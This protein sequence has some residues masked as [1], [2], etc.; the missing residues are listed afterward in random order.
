MLV[1]DF[2]GSSF[3]LKEV[4]EAVEKMGCNVGSATAY[5]ELQQLRNYNSYL[6][7][8]GSKDGKGSQGK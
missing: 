6:S 5:Y 8:R 1:L 2:G 7:A 3:G 4:F